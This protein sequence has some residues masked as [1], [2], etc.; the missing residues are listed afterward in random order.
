MAWLALLPLLWA[1]LAL[2]ARQARRGVWLYGLVFALGTFIWMRL[3]GMVPWLL[4]AGYLSLT[5]WLAL[6]L[7]QCMPQRRWLIPLGF[8]LAW[9]GLEWLRGLGLFGL[10]WA[11]VGASQVDGFTAHIAAVGG[12][13]LL[14]FLMLWVTGTLLQQLLDRQWSPALTAIVLT[15]LLLCIGAGEW[16]VHATRARWLR[17]PATLH[18]ALIQP[19]SLRGLSPEDLKPPATA[20]EQAQ[21]ELKRRQRLEA[22]LTLS[23]QAADALHRQPGTGTDDCLLIWPETSLLSRRM[24][25][26]S[27]SLPGA[28]AA[29]CGRRPRGGLSTTPAELRVAQCRLSHCPNRHQHGALRQNAPGTF[30]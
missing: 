29:T 24:T 7:T 26:P 23:T 18:L 22:L 21:W 3:F 10:P 8:A 13:P 16:Q 17:Q 9:C 20:E 15:V 19:D 6:R 28:P 4:L 25:R 5:P 11:E 1:V 12:L 2:P 30:R 27:G 14:T